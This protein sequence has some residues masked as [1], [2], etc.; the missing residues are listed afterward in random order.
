MWGVRKWIAV[1]AVVGAYCA[2]LSGCGGSKP[3]KADTFGVVGIIKVDDVNVKVTDRESG[4]C[5]SP[6]LHLANAVTI[7][8]PAGKAVALAKV[9]SGIAPTVGKGKYFSPWRCNIGFYAEDLPS[10]AGV[11]TIEVAGHPDATARFTKDQGD[12]R[13][14]VPLDVR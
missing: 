12:R 9:R 1:T 3:E 14:V 5:H 6:D 8:D 13:V 4:E 11:F 7:R 2:L 10:V